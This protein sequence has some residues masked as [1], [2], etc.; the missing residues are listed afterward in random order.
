MIEGKTIFT[1]L[2]D[3]LPAYDFRKCVDHYRGNYK[4]KS[5]SSWDQYLCMAFA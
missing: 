5:F 3:F 2:M 4:V 1:P